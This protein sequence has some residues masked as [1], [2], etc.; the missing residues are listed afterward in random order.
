MCTLSHTVVHHYDVFCVWFDSKCI[1]YHTLATIVI[2]VSALRLGGQGLIPGLVLPKTRKK[3]D[4][5]HPFWTGSHYLQ[6]KGVY[7]Y[8]F[9]L[10]DP[11][12]FHCTNTHHSTVHGTVQ[13]TVWYKYGTVPYGTEQ[14][15]MAKYTTVWCSIVK[16]V[17]VQ[18][19]ST[20]HSMVQY[21]KEQY[22]VV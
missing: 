15:G 13:Y 8:T 12:H 9:T 3:R 14:Y 5:V 16:Y 22:V 20:V 19:Y 6:L 10:T 18:C 7:L 1:C 4:P 11:S 2:R 21:S 17:T